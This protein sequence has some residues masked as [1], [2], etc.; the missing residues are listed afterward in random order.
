VLAQRTGPE[1]R[2]TTVQERTTIDPERRTIVQVQITARVQI[3]VRE[4]PETSPGLITIDRERAMTTAQERLTT[5]QERL[6]TDR[7]TTMLRVR[8]QFRGP[9]MGRISRTVA[10]T[11]GLT[12][13][14]GRESRV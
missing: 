2:E 9:E 12:I 4:V 14:M 11:H 3:R 7:R 1:R 10:R 6:T 5:A 8:E 13:R